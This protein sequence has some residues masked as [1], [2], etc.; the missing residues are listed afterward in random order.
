[1]L[2]AA[3]VGCGGDAT[4]VQNPT[5]PSVAGVYGINGSFSGSLP[6]TGTI[7]FSQA[8]R[9]QPALTGTAN[10]TVTLDTETL[11]FTTISNASI[12]E[13]G[14][15][16]FNIGLTGGST[17]WRFQGTLSGGTITGTHTITDGADSETGTFTAVK[18]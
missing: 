13:A 14:L 5:F 10:I 18:Q 7:T 2:M 1:M 11:T 3:L 4:G 12:S 16:G 9:E 15:I 17:S 8:S 6:F